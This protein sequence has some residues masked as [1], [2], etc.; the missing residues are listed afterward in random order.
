MFEFAQLNDESG[1][2][3]KSFFNESTKLDWIESFSG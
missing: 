3:D 1:K 2:R